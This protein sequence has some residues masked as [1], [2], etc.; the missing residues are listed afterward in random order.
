M[1]QG[2]ILVLSGPSG[3]GKSTIISAASGQIGEYYFSISTTTRSPREGEVDGRDYFFVSKESFEEDIKAGNFLEYAQVHGNYYGTSLK[4]VREALDAGKLV[5]FDI[6]VQGHR[7]VRAKL[8]DI[9][10]SAF[11]T[12]PT[13]GVLKSRLHARET[14]DASVIAKRI[15]NAKGE[16]MA[17]GEYDFTII[18]DSVEEATRRFVII[19]NAARLK[20]SHALQEEFVK[21][22]LALD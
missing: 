9:T 8:N 22:W 10:T 14:D 17:L 6:D 7:L 16:I 3:A 21:Q 1:S 15:E 11:I 4:P 12:P 5:I 18:N 2:A 13:L 20:Q 19:A